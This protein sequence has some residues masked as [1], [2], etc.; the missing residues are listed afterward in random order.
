[1]AD[2]E[3]K[4]REELVAEIE[5]LEAENDNP[6]FFAKR[7]QGYSPGDYMNCCLKCEQTFIGDKRASTCLPCAEKTI[8]EALGKFQEIMER[9]QGEQPAQV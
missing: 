9:R 2:T 6:R 5:R 3:G 4:S 8:Q 1:M 7:M